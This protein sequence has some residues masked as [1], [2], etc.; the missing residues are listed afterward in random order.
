[1]KMR[2]DHTTRLLGWTSHLT[3]IVIG[4]A[5]V[6]LLAVATPGMA[7]VRASLDRS[8]VYEGDTFTLTIERDGPSSRL[9]P[10]L[11]PL[12]KDF[13]VL[14]TQTSTRVTIING[15]RSDT[16][17]WQVQ[18]QPRRL[19]QLRVPSLE[20][21]G[22]KTSPIPLTVSEA[23]QQTTARAGRHVFIETETATRGK[24]VYVQQQIPYTLRLFY[25]DRLQAGEIQ[26]PEPENAVV[27]R[28]GEDRR[29]DTVRDGRQYHV[30]ERNYVISPEK[31]GDLHIPPASFRGRIALPQAARARRPRSPMEEFLENS[32]FANDPFF[33]NRLGGGLFD[34]P[35]ARP[36]QPVHVRGRAIDL[37]IKPR[38]AAAGQNWLPAEAVTLTDSWTEDPPQ[39][40][41]GEPVSRTITLQARGLSASQIPDL[42]LAAPAGARIYPEASQ[43]ENRTDGQTIYGV[44]RQTFT[45]IPGAPGTLEV[46][47]ITVDW[48]DTRHDQPAS[49]TL[50]AWQIEVLPGAPGSSPAAPPPAPATH[51]SGAKPETTPASQPPSTTPVTTWLLAAG[52]ALLAVVLLAAAWA[53]YARR[54]PPGH[55]SN[56]PG[57]RQ[58]TDRAKR[59]AALRALQQACA[60]NHRRAAAQALLDL[61]RA[62][63]PDDPPR[64]LGALAARIATGQPLLLE[65][66]RSLYAA[67]G[68]TWNGAALWD[69][70]RHG[71]PEE[72]HHPPAQDDVLNPLYPQHP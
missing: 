2:V 5:L 58:A 7:A 12:K 11:G 46:P 52:G 53:R 34:D 30:I 63:W 48:W 22:E 1:M 25:D 36:T 41:V 14:G 70:F 26:A 10:D 23:P 57:R 40:K 55:P 32:P 9:Q 31:S 68:R 66:D 42:R 4:L 61:A 50:P 19:G 51:A 71:L 6:L 37:T 29:Y 39:L 35:F 60:G 3:H 65:L 8:V 45:Y 15:R 72:R 17:R 33:R 56:A 59:K 47:P 16:T 24:P 18:L 49:T 67:D 28:L 38:P 20:V 27:E 21:G 43:Q 62:E 64:S 44:R 54:R 69:A 13:E